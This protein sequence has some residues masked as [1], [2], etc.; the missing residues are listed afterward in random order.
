MHAQRARPRRSIMLII[1]IPHAYGTGGAGELRAMVRVS[2][3]KTECIIE[4]Y[5]SYRGRAQR[6]MSEL[7]NTRYVESQSPWA[8]TLQYTL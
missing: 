2:R 6:E 8:S 5:R 3:V 4:S 1:D 7:A